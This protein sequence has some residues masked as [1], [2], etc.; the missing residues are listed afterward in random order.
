MALYF[1]SRN[2]P[3][4]PLVS[5]DYRT[6]PCRFISVLITVPTPTVSESELLAQ[7]SE[8]LARDQLF[9]TSVDQKLK[10]GLQVRAIDEHISELQHLVDA[11][12]DNSG[13]VALQ[14]KKQLAQWPARRE[15]LLTELY[16]V[17]RFPDFAGM[18]FL[19]E[20][21]LIDVEYQDN[22]KL[23]S[24][25]GAL[26][27]Y[28]VRLSQGKSGKF[29]KNLWVVHYHYAGH[30][31]PANEFFLAHIKTWEQRSYGSKDAKRLAAQGDR[32]HRELL[33]AEQ[34]KTIIGWAE[35]TGG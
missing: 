4:S 22:R 30:A 11:F 29:G 25:G 33:T 24:D 26:D 35:S 9:R 10:P 32:I 8:V 31:D 20:R 21:D 1:P 2:V 28:T 16:K 34:G 17:T 15:S 5:Q 18:R 13:A 6:T 23:L 7:A 27:A 14:V 12:G 19:K 3:S